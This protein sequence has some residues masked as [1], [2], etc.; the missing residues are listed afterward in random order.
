MD[1]PKLPRRTLKDIERENG[2]P[3][4]YNFDRRSQYVLD[5]DEWKWD[6]LPEIM[7]GKNVFDFIDP[8]IDQKLKEL[9]EEEDE[10]EQAYNEAGIQMENDD[11]ELTEEQLELLEQIRYKRAMAKRLNQDKKTNNTPQVPRHAKGKDIEEIQE[12]MNAYGIDITEM[13]QRSKSKVRGRKRTRDEDDD[14][15]REDADMD[16]DATP[17]QKL[18]RLRSLSRNSK[19][20]VGALRSQSKMRGQTPEPGDGFVDPKQKKKAEKL[21]KIQQKRIQEYGKKGEADRVVLDPKPRHLFSGKRG[22]GSTD[23]R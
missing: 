13:R 11:D 9:E 1:T 5:H 19:S 20:H 22:I 8:E 2:G 18:Q 6:I 23:R 14:S 21:E 10:L 12:K 3:G 4:V 7:D 17:V 16:V 15:R